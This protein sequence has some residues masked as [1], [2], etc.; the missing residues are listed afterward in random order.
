MTFSMKPCSRHRQS[1]AL[2]AAGAVDETTA[3]PLRRHLADCP[4]CQWYFEEIAGASSVLERAGLPEAPRNTNEFHREVV[5]SIVKREPWWSRTFAAWARSPARPAG[6]ALALAGVVLLLTLW[7]SP[8][9]GHGVRSTTQPKSIAQGTVPPVA[10]PTAAPG[11]LAYY[12]GL[13]EQSLSA[14]DEDL[15]KR[16]APSGESSRW[17]LMTA[18]WSRQE[19]WE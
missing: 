1:L 4:A 18:G 11:S 16:A 13:A 3:G 15:S 7:P 10:D 2:L 12:R 6:V 14:L 17:P 19:A 5:R 8:Q 9:P